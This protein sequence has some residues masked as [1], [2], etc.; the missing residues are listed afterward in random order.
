MTFAFLVHPRTDLRE[1]LA[2]MWRP[3]GLLPSAVY[4]VGLRRLPVPPVNFA[5]IRLQQQRV[6]D[7]ILVPFGARHLLQDRR[8]S[9]GKISS[10]VDR[11]VAAG[12]DLVGLGGLTAPVTNGGMVLRKRSDIG[13][14]NGN[15]F[16]AAIVH[17]QV[18]ELLHRS[19]RGR[20]GI[21][22]A[23][24][25]VGSAVTRLLARDGTAAELVLVA[26]GSSALTSLANSLGRRVPTRVAHTIGAV[27]DCDIVVL[28]TAAA[29]TVL[30]SEHLRFG[31]TVLDAT[32]PR[33]TSPD[34][35]LQRPDV[36]V[37]D[38]GVVDVAG[39]SL[40]GGSMGLPDGQTFA[41][42]AETMLLSLSN[43]R[44]HFTLGR[45]TLD[46]VD[47]V[48]ELAVA[49]GHLGFRPAPPS[50]FGRQWPNGFD[51]PAPAT[52][53]SGGPVSAVGRAGA[54]LSA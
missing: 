9:V 48:S 17:R 28:L 18:R 43:H 50:S 12:A 11:A 40:H 51:L 23:S 3:L 29:D 38:G 46:Q 14:T 52:A 54:V 36:L 53:Q 30:R 19:R 2:R 35:Q 37:L 22:G 4:D 20:V 16:T 41:C 13:V 5:E 34:L 32:Q 21:V 26:R 27:A 15:A 39:M 25:S 8:A 44:G 6:G 31:A 45:P 42:L 7:L 1:D 33:N 47:H 10:A 24:G 49:H